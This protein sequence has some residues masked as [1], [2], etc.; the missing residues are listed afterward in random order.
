[1]QTFGELKSLIKN[2]VEYINFDFQFSFD[3]CLVKLLSDSDQAFSYLIA[4]MRIPLNPQNK[5]NIA[6]NLPTLAMPIGIGLLMDVNKTL[7]ISQIE[8][9]MEEQGRNISDIFQFTKVIEPFD[10]EELLDCI[11]G[12]RV[13]LDI[14]I[15][16][17][18]D[19]MPLHFI[20]DCLAV[21]SDK[22]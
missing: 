22:G 21:M 19:Q 16:T 12:E 20:Q 17:L 9:I 15:A 7:S 5:T 13:F 3:L 8:S 2:K 10:D 11:K 18:K 14:L 1:M 6:Y 4:E